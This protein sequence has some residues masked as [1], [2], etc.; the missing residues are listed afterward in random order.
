MPR[1]TPTRTP[2]PPGNVIAIRGEKAQQ[3]IA[4]RAALVRGSK[5]VTLARENRALHLLIAGFTYQQIADDLGMRYDGVKDLI[6]RAL[7]RHRAE[8]AVTREQWRDILSARHERVLQAWMPAALG[9]NPKTGEPFAE[10]DP[11]AAEIVHRHLSS[12]A[13]LHHV[14]Q[15]PTVHVGVEVQDPVGAHLQRQLDL[16][17]AARRK[18]LELANTV[19]GQVVEEGETG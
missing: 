8:N 7:A 4:P 13:R 18:R 10:P 6:P 14:E 1:K 15:M 19:D 16:L 17:E 12:L 11:K 3:G 5:A 9:L 2:E